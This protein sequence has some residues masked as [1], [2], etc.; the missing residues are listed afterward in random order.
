MALP[1]VEAFERAGLDAPR[2]VALAQ[3]VVARER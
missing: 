2:L 1:S 3:F